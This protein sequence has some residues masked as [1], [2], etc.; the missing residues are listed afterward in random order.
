M[1]GEQSKEKIV[2]FLESISAIHSSC[3]DLDTL[4]RQI[5]RQAA[6]FYDAECAFLLLFDSIAKKLKFQS[7]FGVQSSDLR[8]LNF[9]IGE[10]IAGWAA[11]NKKPLI[12]N[13]NSENGAYNLSY[14][15]E[16]TGFPADTLIAVPLVSGE[17]IIGV[18]E[19]IN[20]NN[21]GSFKDS[22]IGMLEMFTAQ[23][24]IALNNF[25]DIKKLKDKLNAI[26]GQI[27]ELQVFQ[28]FIARSPVMKEKLEIIDRLAK[29]DSSVL[30]LGESGVGKELVAEQIH[31]R[32]KRKGRPFI[33]LNCAALT[34][35]LAESELFG[36]VKG[37]FTGAV[38]DRKGRFE[39]AHT[40]TIFLDEIADMP[41]NLQAKILRVLQEKTFEKVGSDI[42]ISVDVR[43]LAATNK[44]IEK[45]VLDGAF[46]KDLY[47]RLN[48]L[49]V[50]VP[51]LRQRTEDIPELAA[52]FLK[53]M[54]ENVKKRFSGFS[55]EAMEALISYPWPGN[56]R[57]LGNCIERACVISK[58]E[59]IQKNDLLISKPNDYNERYAE[60]RDLK[61][62]EN[63]FKAHFLRT[64]LEENKWNQTAAARALD[65]QRT[66]LSRL[67]KELNINA[68]N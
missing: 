38:N 4:S 20:K 50:F 14:F 3:A 41:L 29:T 25:A 15:L 31:L 24:C 16:K 26:E 23:C 47:Y 61:T 54:N 44:D 64:V 62:A 48:V 5:V 53:K 45:L 65:I 40:G 27:N 11:Q 18:L 60:G 68:K 57:E 39:L 28:P 42:H 21:G 13:R 52:F 2:L 7:V 6:V 55:D 36:H 8:T 49:P 67:I 1:S 63:A 37:A 10:G 19:I 43:I 66:Y 22:D 17:T 35:E 32:S 59:I 34:D 30:I 46:R 33:R 51:P 12:I 9:E 58:T 56:I